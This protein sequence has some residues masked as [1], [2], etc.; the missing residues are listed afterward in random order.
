MS[1]VTAQEDLGKGVLAIIIKRK[2]FYALY[3]A[4]KAKHGSYLG[5]NAWVGPK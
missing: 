3:I 5:Y 2:A 4:N 1:P